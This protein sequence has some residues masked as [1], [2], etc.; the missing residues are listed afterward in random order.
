[1]KRTTFVPVIIMIL[2][3]LIL[4]GVPLLVKDTLISK[5]KKSEA[6]VNR[7]LPRS[8][9]S[10][11][12]LIEVK[13]GPG[14]KVEQIYQVYNIDASRIDST[15]LSIYKEK[16]YKRSYEHLMKQPQ[17]KLFRRYDG[18]YIIT[19]MDRNDS[20]FSQI[21]IKFETKRSRGQ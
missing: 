19:S 15:A 12:T 7:K 13:M 17:A 3:L 1:M 4:R 11:T 14:L 5:L 9:D 20:V 2:F 18:E 21:P 6:A 16:T 8:I 10:F